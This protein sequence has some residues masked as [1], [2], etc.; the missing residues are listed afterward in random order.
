M[1]ALGALAMLGAA[2]VVGVI[3]ALFVYFGPGPAAPQ[4]ASTTVVLAPGA[5]VTEIA[6]D[7]RRGRVIGSNT[8]FVLAAELTGAAHKLKAG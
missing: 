6:S 7:L 3:I 2:L 1:T 8:V 4:G 5:G